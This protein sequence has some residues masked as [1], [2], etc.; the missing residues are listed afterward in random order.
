MRLDRRVSWTAPRDRPFGEPNTPAF[1]AF[2]ERVH[3]WLPSSHEGLA[4]VFYPALS[5]YRLTQ[6][7][8]F[9]RTGHS[10][11]IAAVPA[12]P[13]VEPVKS[14]ECHSSE[15]CHEQSVGAGLL[16]LAQRSP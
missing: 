3:H 12:S 9:L 16:W 8:L 1:G 15:S 4:R 2:P 13:L 6:P 11:A 7:L 5:K 10:P 14:D